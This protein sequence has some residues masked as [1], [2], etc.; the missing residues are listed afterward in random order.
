MKLYKPL[1][2]IYCCLIFVAAG[3][4]AQDLKYLE[5]DTDL[6]P[7]QVYKERREKLLQQIGTEAV[8]IF[9]RIRSATAMRIWI[10][11]MRRTATFII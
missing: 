11:R 9:I 5:Y 8:A 4:G 2:W 6:I 1:V 7:G 10:F 3:A